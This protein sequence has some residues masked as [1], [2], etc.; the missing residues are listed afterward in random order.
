M[1]GLASYKRIRHH[2][3]VR[4]PYFLAAVTWAYLAWSLL[5]L[6]AAFGTSVGRGPPLYE[7]DLT[8]N[9][10]RMALRSTETRGAFVHSVS[11][12]LATVIVAVPMGTALGVA[13]AHL[14]GR[15]WR[16]VRAALLTM[17]AIPHV[18]LAVVFQY[19]FLFAIQLHLN[20]NA[21]VIG[22]VTLALPFVALIVWTRLFFLDPS[23]EE[24]ATD[25]GAPPLSVV[26]RV[27]L[28]L[29]T[30]AIVVA[31]TVAFA[32]SFNEL[33]VSQY[34]CAPT[35][36]QTVP[37]FIGGRRGAGEV[38]PQ[39]VAIAVIATGLSAALLALMLLTT[40]FLRRRWS[41]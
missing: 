14:K 28:P 40:H 5:P 3:L 2:R 31:A 30:P 6:V 38:P 17:I 25:L 34:L 23:Y 24:Q 35:E 21:Q 13:L 7:E 33:P 41:R 19:L 16:A 1:S 15:P 22:H 39:A 37:M 18:A 4:R 9:A 20:S 36:C 32:V 26:T 29:C 27:L 12:A 8:F 11:L 10:Y